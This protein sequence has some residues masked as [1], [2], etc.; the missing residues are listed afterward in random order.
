MGT[1]VLS[2]ALT[3]VYRTLRDLGDDAAHQLLTNE[4]MTAYIDQAASRYSA[5]RPGE[6]V[7][8][9]LS[10]GT[11]VLTLP[12]AFEEGFSVIYSIEYPIGETPLSY[13]DSRSW[14]LYRTPTGLELR[15]GG[16]PTTG[17]SLR[18]TTS[19]RRAFAA[20]AAETTVL[21]PD[22]DAVCDLAVANCADAIAQKYARTHEPVLSA[23]NVDYKS[24]VDE[25]ASRARR[26]EARY[27]AAIGPRTGSVVI[28]WDSNPSFRGD[29]LVHRRH[30]R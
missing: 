5:D 28:N 25:W 12:A 15:L 29:W 24:K 22:F 30:R 9:I 1:Y 21:D 13:L 16:L 19:V 17:E 4:E 26:Y 18:V 11:T 6:A 3:R 7:E 14:M 2:D 20:V 8:D 10:D 27:R 23:D